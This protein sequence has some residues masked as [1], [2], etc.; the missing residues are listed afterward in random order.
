MHA[1]RQSQIERHLR[2]RHRMTAAIRAFF[3]HRDY[4]EVETPVRIPA[5]APEAH[6]EPVPSAD[7]YLQTSPEL[8]M[9][10]LLAAGYP[11]VYQI[12]RC[13]RQGERGRRHLP[14]MTLLE[15]YTAHAD[16]RD[17]MAQTEALILSV[18]DVLL[19]G[20]RTLVYQGRPVDLSPPWERV[21][22]ADAFERYAGVS[23]RQ[24]VDRGDFDARM[25]LDIESRLGAPRP[26]F[27]MDYPAAHGA[28]ARR[29]SNQPEEVERFELYI[30]GLEL[31][32]A[33][34]ELTDAGEQRRRF[35]AERAAR[36]NAGKT[37]APMPEPFLKDLAGLPP[38]TG[39]A[40][41]VDRLAMLFAD[42]AEIDAVS[43]F[44][45]EEL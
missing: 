15:W 12:C 44:V 42:A 27:L 17:M 25:G 10:R 35:D 36:R 9:K 11:R 45:P 26:V 7:W 30:A 18:A 19:D 22:V 31:C 16:Y 39:N 1:N 21:R 14:E 2:N 20:G 8:C 32:N 40:L 29:K 28:L 41:G 13:F 34:S 23:L 6:I 3:D 38:C 4:L 33:F 37:L 24:A 43:A 5:P